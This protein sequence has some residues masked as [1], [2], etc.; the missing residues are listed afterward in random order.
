MMNPPTSIHLKLSG[1]EALSTI[2]ACKRY[3]LAHAEEKTI[4]EN[5]V[6]EVR[7]IPMMIE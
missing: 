6:E 2:S 1:R 5:V 3:A 4:P 7:Y